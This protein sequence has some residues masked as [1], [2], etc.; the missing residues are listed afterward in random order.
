MPC[1]FKTKRY[2]INYKEYIF[3]KKCNQK[4]SDKIKMNIKN[5]ICF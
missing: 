2:N 1:D 5:P 3:T 4:Y